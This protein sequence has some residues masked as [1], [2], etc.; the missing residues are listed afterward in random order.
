V[1]KNKKVGPEYTYLR[2]KQFI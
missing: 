2:G 1:K